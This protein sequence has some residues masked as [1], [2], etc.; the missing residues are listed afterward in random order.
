MFH[1]ILEVKNLYL[2]TFKTG[3]FMSSYKLLAILPPLL[4]SVPALSEQVDQQQSHVDASVS[5]SYADPVWQSFIPK[6]S[7]LSAIS[8]DLLDN[9]GFPVDAGEVSISLHK[10]DINAYVIAQ[11]ESVVLEDCFNVE[12]PAGCGLGGGSTVPIKF[13][14]PEDV[15]LSADELYT[16]KVNIHNGSN[17][18]IGYSYNDTYEAG[19]FSRNGE[20][21]SGDLAFST[22]IPDNSEVNSFYVSSQN[23]IYQYSYDGNLLNAKLIEGAT[24]SANARD[25]IHLPADELAIFN[26]V[27]EPTLSVLSVD[28]WNHKT[29]DGWSIANNGTYGGIT[30]DDNYFYLGDMSTAYAGSLKGLLRVTKDFSSTERYFD[31]YEF[32]DLTFGENGYLYALR[33]TYGDLVVI[34]PKEMTIVAEVDLGHTSSSRAVTADSEGTIYMASWNGDISKYDAAGNLL[35]SIDIDGSLTDI[36]L[37]AD[38]ILIGTR[39]GDVHLLSTDL[40]LISSFQVTNGITFTSF[41]ATALKPKPEPE[42]DVIAV[43]NITN[44]WSSGYCAN[45]ELTNTSSEAVTW[46]VEVNIDGD[47]NNL[48]NANWEQQGSIL[49]VSGLSWNNTLAAGSVNTS[50]G[51]CASK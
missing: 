35:E 14:F 43:V 30:A 21:Q 8:L 33:N 24:S 45:L 10:G 6:S 50:I 20:L 47:I 25:L 51:F 12:Q 26:G 48:W 41:Y 18:N 28:G 17:V 9:G 15:N 40:E 31:H 5:I 11:S 29:I 27:F 36:D 19:S 46:D 7:A 2:L 37:Q 1:S 49:Q 44:E 23:Y 39:A 42:K 16:F 3:C 34:D 4:L 22:H 13:S 38:R 32:I